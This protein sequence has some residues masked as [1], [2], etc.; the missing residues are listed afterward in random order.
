MQLAQDTS[1]VHLS[2]CTNIHAGDHWEDVFPQLQRDIPKVKARVCPQAPFGIGLRVS[3]RMSEQLQGQTLE[4]FKNWLAAEDLYVFTINGFPY[5]PFHGTAVKENVYQPDWTDTARLTY[6]IDLI[7]LCAALNPPEGYA[8][9][10]TVPGTYKQWAQGALPSISDNLLQAIAH[11]VKV[12]Q[13]TGVTV[14]LSLEPEPCCLLETTSEAVAFFQSWL[15]S[16]AAIARLCQLSE[17]SRAD[18]DTAIHTHIGVCYDVCHS[19]VEY[20]DSE[21]SLTQLKSAG[22]PIVKLQLSSALQVPQVDV[23][24]LKHL[25]AFNE[26]VYLHQVVEKRNGRLHRFSDLNDAIAWREACIRAEFA[27][28]P[29]MEA[30]SAAIDIHNINISENSPAEWR[31]HFHVPVFMEQLPHFGTTQKELLTVLALQK[32]STVSR[33]LEVE[34]YTWDVLPAECRNVE[35]DEAIARELLWVKDKL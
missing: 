25:T 24:S 12:K 19:A 9:I 2:Y 35:I 21:L 31:V 27:T 1:P 11:C 33:H 14:A 23:D 30:S 16:D 34:T 29:A 18:A 4:E 8:S 10:S 22:I 3:K 32:A 17:C 13:E 5:G 26:P 7:N 6:T 28:V 20:E 15:Y